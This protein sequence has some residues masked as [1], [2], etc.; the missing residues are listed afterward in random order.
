[1][2]RPAPLAVANL[3]AALTSDAVLVHPDYSK[4]FIVMPDASIFAVGGV[5]AQLDSEGRERHIS[6][7]SKKLN[8]AEQKYAV[9]E[10]EA[11]GVVY[12]VRKFRHYIE[13]TTFRLVTDNNT[14]LWLFRQPILRGK[15]ARWALDLQQFDFTIEHRAGRAH[16][17][18]D[19]VS[20]LPR[21][22]DHD[23]NDEQDVP[24]DDVCD[25][26]FT[27]S[28]F[29][30][31]PLHATLS[32]LVAKAQTLTTAEYEAYPGY[33]P[34]FAECPVSVLVS[35]AVAQQLDLAK[36]DIKDGFHHVDLEFLNTPSARVAP[37]G[38]SGRVTPARPEDARLSSD[39]GT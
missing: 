36:F 9:Y 14:L 35:L 25:K 26:A 19:A 24:V 3:K 12:S 2:D 1:M 27:V 6:L 13:G 30:S 4:P 15:L 20:R 39:F 17:V 7:R 8:A 38:S 29:A 33:N 34:R 23:T 16:I 21:V 37:L 18:P 31:A 10:L 5:L 28:N 22:D 32:S 11:L